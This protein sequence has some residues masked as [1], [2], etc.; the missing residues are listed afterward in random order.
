MIVD[1]CKGSLDEAERFGE[2]VAADVE[3]PCCYAGFE[4]AGSIAMVSAVC[5][6]K[7]EWLEVIGFATEVVVVGIDD[8]CLAMEPGCAAG[9][10]SHLCVSLQ[11]VLMIAKKSSISWEA[12]I[13][14]CSA[15]WR[16]GVIGS[17]AWHI[18]SQS[19]SKAMPEA[20]IC[21]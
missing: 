6:G 8:D 2:V 4:Q 14:S 1:L 12:L 16:A 11:A 17:S 19:C 20:H 9:D 21:K 3:K 18:L 15:S 13:L 7:I 10:V 5:F